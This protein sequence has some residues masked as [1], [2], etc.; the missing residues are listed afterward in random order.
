V[1][2]VGRDGP[3]TLIVDGNNVVG[4]GVACW[5]RDPPAAVR[6]LV[7]RLRCYA[8]EVVTSNRALAEGLA[9]AARGSPVRAPSWRAWPTAA[10]DR[11]ERRRPQAATQVAWK[12]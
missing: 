11:G 3:T 9:G 6:R 12:P 2:D 8:A 4:A 5:W 7:D 1:G 10:A